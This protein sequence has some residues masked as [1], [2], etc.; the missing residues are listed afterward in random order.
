MLHSVN[1]AYKGFS[2]FK[3]VEDLPANIITGSKILLHLS[4]TNVRGFFQRASSKRI[5]NDWAFS[6]NRFN[7]WLEPMT[8]LRKL[9]MILATPL[10]ISIWL[11]GK[12]RVRS[13]KFQFLISA[14]FLHFSKCS[15][16]IM[17]SQYLTILPKTCL[18]PIFF[19]P[20][21]KKSK[22]N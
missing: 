6:L 7:C 18:L 5:S 8:L 20:I 3:K 14:L 9:P 12:W 4:I 21:L 1:G 15:G 22:T 2:R 19:Q 11:R 16:L 13:S 10:L 17:I